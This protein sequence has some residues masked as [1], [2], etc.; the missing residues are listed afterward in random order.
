MPARF[1]L[2]CHGATAATRAAAFPLDEPLEA[3]AMERAAA[4]RGALRRADR[5]LVSPALRARQT[6]EA[7]GLA[8]SVDPL[9]RDGDHGRWNG[10]GIGEIQAEDPEGVL[11]WRTDPEAAPHGGE[12]L[13]AVMRRAAAWLDGQGRA[14]GHVVAVT[15]AAVIRAAILFAVGAPAAAFWHLDVGPLSLTDLR[16][17]AA[18]WTW[19]ATSP[20]DWR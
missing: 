16:F 14:S 2:I 20:T 12:S 3:H 1:S 13:A 19:R 9:L 17:D 18:R 15:H 11:A 4:L 8:A 7:L 5:I 6:A 10:R